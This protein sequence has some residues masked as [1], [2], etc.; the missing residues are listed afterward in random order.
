MIFT[1]LING[2][3][4]FWDKIMTESTNQTKV[5]EDIDDAFDRMLDIHEEYHAPVTKTDDTETEKLALEKE[6]QRLAREDELRKRQEA[7]KRKDQRWKNRHGY[8]PP[9]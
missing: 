4:S 7:K 9:K 1:K 3:L 5:I 2:K 8:I 6:K